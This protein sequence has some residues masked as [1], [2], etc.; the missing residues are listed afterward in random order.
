M[1]TKANV[2]D[3]IPMVKRIVH[4]RFR[5]YCNCQD[6]IDNLISEGTLYLINAYNKDDKDGNLEAY[7]FISVYDRLKT[8]IKKWNRERATV[9]VD[10]YIHNYEQRSYVQTDKLWLLDEIEKQLRD[11]RTKTILRLVRQGLTMEE[12][13]TKLR[14]SDTV[15]V[16]SYI[17]RLKYN[18]VRLMKSRST[19][20]I[21]SQWMFGR[22]DFD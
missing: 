2:T 7:L 17:H 9:K 10:E 8:Y 1:Q 4:K 20:I 11:C 13:R 16:S 15:S 3:Y 22:S 18:A 21:D 6:D 14:L 12:I 19:G 5:C